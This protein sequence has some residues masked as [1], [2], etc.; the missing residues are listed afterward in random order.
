[1]AM[2]QNAAPSG[3]GRAYLHLAEQISKRI[4][5]GTYNLGDKLPAERELAKRF[6]VSRT[7]V[8][9]ALRILEKTEIIESVPGKGS[10]VRSLR[11][12]DD[13]IARH[14]LTVEYPEL[15]ELRFLLERLAAKR[16]VRERGAHFLVRLQQI[17]Q[18]LERKAQFGQYDGELDNAF[19]LWIIENGGSRLLKR[20]SREIQQRLMEYAGLLDCPDAWLETLPL[21]RVILDALI[22]RDEKELAA[23]YDRLHA[24]D[25]SI[26]YAHVPPSP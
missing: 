14:S 15:I 5:S 10:F 3:R 8:R 2:Q 1:M 22:A 9:E 21:H 11:H 24:L 13:R 26:I 12:D 20:F 18:Q 6:G 16:L 25:C 7:T 17:L 23:A 19:H 4:R